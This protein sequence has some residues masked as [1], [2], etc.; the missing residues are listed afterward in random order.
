LSKI[1]VKKAVCSRTPQTAREVS[2][3]APPKAVQEDCK[4]EVANSQQLQNCNYTLTMLLLLMTLADRVLD[5]LPKL[6]FFVPPAGRRTVHKRGRA[7]VISDPIRAVLWLL[8]AMSA[9][10]KNGEIPLGTLRKVL[11]RLYPKDKITKTIAAL[12][13]TDCIRQGF[14]AGP[15]SHRVLRLTTF[16]TQVVQE[17]KDE[18][19]AL[20][21]ALLRD[22]DASERTPCLNALQELARAAW[23]QMQTGEPRRKRGPA[24]EQP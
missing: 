21:R 5:L 19:A 8:D 1:A 20:V 7:L 2:K 18:H 23:K 9:E 22:V 15:R 17:I 6:Y 16:G 24:Y 13:E 3:S 10:H 4:A 14:S 11:G 12:V